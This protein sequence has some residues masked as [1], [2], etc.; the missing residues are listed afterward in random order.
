MGSGAVLVTGGAGFIG[1]HLVRTLVERGTRVRVLDDLSTGQRG[2]L[3]GTGAE[4]VVANIRDRRALDGALRG[5]DL[6]Y[7]IAA[8][9]RV[10][11]S[12]EDPGHA[13]DNN[14]GGTV[15]VLLASRDAEVDRVVYASSS[16]VYGDALTFPTKEDA[17][18]TRT[19]SP[20]GVSKLAAE[21]LCHSF[22]RVFELPTVS[23]R[24]FNVYGPGQDIR[25]SYVV[26]R[27]FRALITGAPIE[28]EG[29]G[30]QTRDFVYVQD[31]V[32]ATI[33]AAEA[34]PDAVARSYN[35]GSGQRVGISDIL[36]HLER[37]TGVT[38]SEIVHL[39]ARLGDVHDTHADLTNARAVLRYEPRYDLAA[40]LEATVE[41]LRGRLGQVGY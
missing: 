5:V 19:V 14:I 2:R 8:D 37:I 41:W 30:S 38:H 22:T 39:P 36:G 3:K 29:D 16:A 34:G 10:T 1:A 17:D 32:E 15:Q 25:T 33:M 6:V 20:Y 35:V 12:V 28:I 31:V 24:Y 27:F 21:A 13:L 11:R 26:P 4:L 18:V 23:L 40:G 7:H 9:P